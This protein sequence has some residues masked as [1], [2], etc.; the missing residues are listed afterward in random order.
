[1]IVAINDISFQIE[2]ANRADAR[3][4]L[5]TFGSLCLR[6]KQ[7]DVS[8]VSVPRNIISSPAI[9]QGTMLASGYS[10]LDAMKEIRQQDREIFQFLVSKLTGIGYAGKYT[11]DEMEILGKISRHC[12]HYKD[13]MFISLVSDPVFGKGEVVGNLNGKTEITLCNL[14]KT[15]HLY[16]YWE[17]LG[18]RR[19]E[20]NP[21][22]GSRSYIRAGGTSVGIAPE[23]DMMGQQLLNQVIEY[24][25]KL[26]AVDEKHDCRI[27]EFRQTLGNTYHGFLQE[28]LTTDEQRKILE[29]WRQETNG[30]K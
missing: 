25:G 27:F 17:K 5:L 9:H 20:K 1:M 26:F 16:I 11:T 10:L 22:H 28:Q 6:L 24:N 14:A 21:K 19:Y 13:E 18:Y 29:Q 7:E 12:A 3:D 2:F 23:T 30:T 8:E 15:E 4:A